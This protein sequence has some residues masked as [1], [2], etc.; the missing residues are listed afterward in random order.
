MLENVNVIALIVALVGTAGIGATFRDVVS[1][2]AKVREG[3]SA[4]ESTRKADLVAQRE[5]ALDREQRA[6]TLADQ[7]DLRADAEAARRRRTQEYASRLRRQ[8]LESGITPAEWPVL[9]DTI[10]AATLA[11]LRATPKESPE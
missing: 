9:E 7:A 8:L 6:I 11:E 2:I 1:V 5:A 3:V 4:K 10:P